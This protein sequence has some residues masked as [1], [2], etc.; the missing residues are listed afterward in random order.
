MIAHTQ[1]PTDP[2][3]EC[4]VPRSL[5][6]GEALCASCAENLADLYDGVTCSARCAENWRQTLRRLP[7]PAEIRERAAAIRAGWTETEHRWRAN[8]ETWH[9]RPPSEPD[10]HP[11]QLWTPPVIPDTR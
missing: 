6:T 11:D 10:A 3:P 9:G 4:Y 2:I 8:G 7:S 1:P 5:L